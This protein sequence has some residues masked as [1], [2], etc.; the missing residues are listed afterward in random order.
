MSSKLALRRKQVSM[1]GS[2]CGQLPVCNSVLEKPVSRK[3]VLDLEA[4]CSVGAC[5]VMAL[6]RV[7]ADIR[8]VIPSSILPQGP[9]L[10][11]RLHADAM[12]AGRWRRANERPEDD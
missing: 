10:N 5:A 8:K 6:E 11:T 1:Q 4:A 9:T 2:S 3:L 12:G 7:P